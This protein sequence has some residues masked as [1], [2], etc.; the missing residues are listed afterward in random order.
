MPTTKIYN[1]KAFCNRLYQ[2]GLSLRNPIPD[3]ALCKMPD[4]ESVFF[5]FSNPVS[6]DS[7]LNE[8]EYRMFKCKNKLVPHYYSFVIC[9]S[10][11]V[12]HENIICCLSYFYFIISFFAG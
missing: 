10:S 1:S 2:T 12:N 7:Y 11:N 6:A 3:L 4:H 9:R 8:I 5:C